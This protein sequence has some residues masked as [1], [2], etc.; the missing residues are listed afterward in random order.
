MKASKS[1]GMRR[2]TRLSKNSVDCSSGGGVVR[3]IWWV[4]HEVGILCFVAGDQLG[5]Y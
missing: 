3:E 2:R 5:K 4:L 1:S